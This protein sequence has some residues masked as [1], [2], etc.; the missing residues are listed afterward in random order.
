MEKNRSRIF[1]QFIA[2]LF[3]GATFTLLAIIITLSKICWDCPSY[4][5]ALIVLISIL[6][7]IVTGIITRKYHFKFN[8]ILPGIFVT[9]IAVFL[10]YLGI[11]D[12]S[13]VGG[14][15]LI[16]MMYLIIPAILFSVAINR[17]KFLRGKQ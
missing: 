17:R 1:A 12:W 8:W 7:V 15:G 6:G 10:F 16:S 11:E 13:F 9:L 5:V 4:S 3:G 14:L 2:N